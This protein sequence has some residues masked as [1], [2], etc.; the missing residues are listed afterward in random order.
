[1]TSGDI[2]WRCTA[3]ECISERPNKI[4]RRELM[5]V[6][7]TELLHDDMSS[8]RKSMYRGRRKII[9]TAPTSLF[10]LIQQLKINNIST[11]RNETF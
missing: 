2:S 11:H 8:I 5:V 1:M 4:I 9:P 7:T 10:E 6:E 3:T